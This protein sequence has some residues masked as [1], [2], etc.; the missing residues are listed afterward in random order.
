MHLFQALN[1]YRRLLAHYLRHQWPQMGLLAVILGGTVAVQVAMPLVASYFIDQV[2]SGGD[3]RGLI[4]LALL[5]TA[6]RLFDGPGAALP[7]GPLSVE[8]DGVSLGYTQDAPV[9]RNISLFLEPG[10][11][12]GV[13]GRTGSGKTTLTRL[14]LR[15]YDPLPGVVRLGGISAVDLCLPRAP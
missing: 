1:R 14:L 10:R 11:V 6:P 2:T 8:L 9:L 15:F 7:P 5:A 3:M 13:V 4:V 12:L